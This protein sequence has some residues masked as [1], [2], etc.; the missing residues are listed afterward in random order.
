MA[1]TVMQVLDTT[2]VNVALPHMAGEL[3]ATSDS[4]SWVLTSYLMGSAVFMPLAGFL[5]DRMGRRKY[6][7]ASIAG[8]VITSALCGIATSLPEMV[9]FRFLQG[10]F[11]ASLVPL[12][13]AIMVETFPQ[14]ARGKAMAIWGMGVMV[15]PIMG[16]S[17]G[18]Y[19]TEMAS[20]RWTF[21]IN[22][23]V[24]IASFLLASRFVP[25]TARKERRMDWFGF[26][27]LAIAVACLQLV[28]D[29][30][31]SEDW[32]DSA[33]I[34][35][36]ACAGA[37][38]FAA[39]LWKGLRP[40]AHPIFNLAVLKDRN[41]AVACLIMLSIGL[42][43]FGGQLLLPLFLENL[44]GFPTMT[45]G[46]YLV[47]RGIATFVAMSV[48][49]KLSGKVSARAMV[50]TGLVLSFFGAW[51]MTGISPQ[52]SG[53]VIL[54]P[55]LL[56][57]LGMGLVFVPM[58]A[59]TFATIPRQLASEAAGL[60]SLV[61]SLGAA[62]GISIASTYLN[63]ASKVNWFELRNHITPYN[64]RVS[65]F[66]SPLGLHMKGAGAQVMGLALQQQASVRAFIGTYWLI[67]ASFLAMLPLLLLIRKPPAVRML[68]S[69]HAVAVE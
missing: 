14:E 59:L 31:A 15:A 24:G 12:S 22:I 8:F 36:T 10:V 67:T 40:T 11:G 46:L 30:G 2:I 21:Y 38:A 51:M 48:V 33:T 47:P 61:R 27:T 20:W 65:E 56:Q 6:L 66:L 49:G 58:S 53:S 60:Y 16:P 68:D 45:A 44:L 63:Y 55:M 64:P 4:I 32:F 69:E 3:S 18:G 50:F 35:L 5:T 34:C 17:L 57:G 13:Q 7:L 54:W 28:L 42:G 29:R 37:F 26:S 52:S 25:D 19:L 1:A 41:F 23:P 9:A 43:V 62:I 39:F